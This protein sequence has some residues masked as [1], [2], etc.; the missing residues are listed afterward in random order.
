[1]S[2]IGKK[3]IL[4]PEGLEVKID[5]SKLIVKGPKGELSQDILPEILVKVENKEIKVFPRATS[6]RSQKSKKVKA[7]WGL[8]R[9]LIANMVKGVKEGYEKKLEIQGIGYK[10]ALE[11]ENLVLQIGFTHPV[12]IKTPESI[13]FVV[14]KNIITVS[15]IDK[16][17][18]GQITAKIRQV[19][20][21]E[22]YKGK[23][24][25]Y[26]GEHVRRKEGKKAATT[27]EA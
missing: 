14:E 22:P 26:L 20:P 23:G 8:T 19:R 13:K 2:R 3:P 12:K 5:G 9:A 25:R 24:I 7:F 10:A 18:V 11:G 1:M 17:L 27:T 4:I 21:P 6:V 16:E 15:G